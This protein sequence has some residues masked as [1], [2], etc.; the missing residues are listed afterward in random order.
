MDFIRPFGDI[1]TGAAYFFGYALKLAA[2]LVHTVCFGC[3]SFLECGL[4]GNARFFGFFR[5]FPGLVCLGDDGLHVFAQSGGHIVKRGKDL[6]EF[7]SPFVFDL[8]LVVTVVC[9]GWQLFLLIKKEM[10]ALITAMPTRR[11]S[12]NLEMVW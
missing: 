1:D 11:V 3:F 6:T 5:F 9:I 10:K 12:M 2:G 4:C 8:S 7:V